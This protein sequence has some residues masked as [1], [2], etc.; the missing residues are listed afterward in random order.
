METVP[1]FKLALF[2]DKLKSEDEDEETKA[3]LE[4]EARLA[5]W[6][7]RP[8]GDRGDEP[9][10]PRDPDDGEGITWGPCFRDAQHLESIAALHLDYDTGTTGA[11][12][13]QALGD[14]AFV[15]HTTLGHLVKEGVEK[16]RVI[17]PLSRAISEGREL[18]ALVD[19]ANSKLP[20][21]E[22][23]CESGARG[24]G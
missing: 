22:P 19:W 13:R 12:I 10:E 11:Q 6:E 16:W 2:R 24:G 1:Y 4:Y 21:P 7:S 17:L 14:Y 8:D 23:L 18:H 20:D 9:R 3:V 15:A 5:R